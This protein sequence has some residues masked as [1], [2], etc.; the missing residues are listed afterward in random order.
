MGY[1][2]ETGLEAIKYSQR[3]S[4]KQLLKVFYQVGRKIYFQIKLV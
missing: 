2:Q 1:I 3:K 4:F